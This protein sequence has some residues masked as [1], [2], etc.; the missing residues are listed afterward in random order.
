MVKRERVDDDRDKDLRRIPPPLA[1]PGWRIPDSC[2]TFLAM[3]DDDDDDEEE[4][5]DD[6]NGDEDL[7]INK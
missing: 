7:R 5:D 4:D 2:V 6:D 1:D 3:G